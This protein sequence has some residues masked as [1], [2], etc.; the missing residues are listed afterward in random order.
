MQYLQSNESAVLEAVGLVASGKSVEL[1]TDHGN[2]GQAMTNNGT[3]SCYSVRSTPNPNGT[4]IQ[5]PNSANL[6]HYSGSTIRPA[7]RRASDTP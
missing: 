5:H 3:A 2:N 1:F 4:S 7:K 6:H